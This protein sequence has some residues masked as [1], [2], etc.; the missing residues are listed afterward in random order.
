MDIQT[1]KLMMGV[2]G[3]S[4]DEPQDHF[5]LHINHGSSLQSTTHN[6]WEQGKSGYSSDLSKMGGI[7]FDHDNNVYIQYGIKN[8]N[9]TASPTN[10]E[11]RQHVMKLN[12]EGTYQW[13]KYI[14]RS[15]FPGNDVSHQA[16]DYLNRTTY[17][18]IYLAEQILQELKL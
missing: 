2:A 1:Y 17:T 8:Q 18:V 5:Y 3:A 6:A 14:E 13:V 7:T 12:D 15:G 9:V 4:T 10:G 11:W 16:P